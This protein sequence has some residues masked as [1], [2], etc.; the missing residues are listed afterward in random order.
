MIDTGAGV[1]AVDVPVIQQLQIQPVGAIQVLTAGGPQP[2]QQFPASFS[3][4]GT[5][6]PT[7]FFS[8]VIGANLAGQGIVALIGRDVLRHFVMVYNGVYG[9][10]ILSI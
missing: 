4:P 1:S 5:P 2:Q 6:F 8:F 7:I 9:Q 10:I 3:F